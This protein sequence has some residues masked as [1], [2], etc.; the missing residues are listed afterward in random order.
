MR[1]KSKNK[2]TE[3]KEKNKI[4]KFNIK[5]KIGQKLERKEC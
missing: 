4:S 1:K 3:Q 2:D 5:K